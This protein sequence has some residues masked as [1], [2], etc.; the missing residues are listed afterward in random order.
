MTFYNEILNI[1]LTDILYD[2]KKNYASLKRKGNPIPD[3]F[4]FVLNFLKYYIAVTSH[5]NPSSQLMWSL[6]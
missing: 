6:L 5:T 3:F 1:Y 2:L 4:L